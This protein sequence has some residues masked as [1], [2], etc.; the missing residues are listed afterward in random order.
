MK[1]VLKDIAKKV[2]TKP[3]LNLKK[4]T[5]ESGKPALVID[6][7]AEDVFRDYVISRMPNLQIFG[8]ERPDKTLDLSKETRLCVLVDMVDGTD[9]LERG[10][11]NWCSSA[12]F[13]DPKL[14]LGERI[15]AAFIGVPPEDVYFATKDKEGAFVGSDRIKEVA[16]GSR[17]MSLSDASICF[18]G[19]KSS[20]LVNK[21]Y[22]R[23]FEYIA[24]F[25]DLRIYTLAGMPMVVKLIDKKVNSAKGIDAVFDFV[26]QNPHDVVPGAYIAMKA[27]A[28]VKNL[29]SGNEMTKEDLEKILMMPFNEKSKMKYIIASTLE[30]AEE[31]ESLYNIE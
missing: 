1:A 24:D 30:L 29:N 19:Q 13:F 2:N 10:L 26:G 17:V 27:G 8:E 31:I 7:E 16:G 21:S 25:K 9:L 4:I 28:V 23:L 18:Y 3:E 11:Y 6:V 14:P 12:V 15:I 5:T 20:R 22:R